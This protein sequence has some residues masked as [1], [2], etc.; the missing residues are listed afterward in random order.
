MGVVLAAQELKLD[1]AKAEIDL[2]HGRITLRGPGNLKRIIPVDA[3]G[4][5]YV[6]WCLPPNHPQLTQESIQDLLL[7]NRLRLEG[8][9]EALT[10]RWRGKLAVVGSSAQV[11]NNLTDRGAT[12]LAKDTL[13]VTKHWNVANSII[14]GRFVRRAPL[15]LD[16]ALIVLLGTLTA[17]L[18][19]QFRALTALGLV[20]LTVIAYIAF[21]VALYIQTRYWLPLVLPVGGALVMQYLC[22]VTWRVVFEQ[23][24][25]RRVKGLLL[26][27]GFAQGG[28]RPAPVRETRAGRRAARDNR[29]VCR[30]ARLYPV[31]R[32]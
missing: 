20:A 24:E 5:A 27:H 19:W 17:V 15:A 3:D 31:H 28:Q 32:R 22:L 18:T 14:T 8:Q 7:Q 21:A 9:T 23:A 16:L 10:N 2:P 25:Q 1:L 26:H 29:P 11:G 30:R 4:Y 6:D 13:L 12:P